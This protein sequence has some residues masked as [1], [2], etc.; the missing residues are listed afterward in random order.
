[1]WGNKEQ[2][3]F[4]L[5]CLGKTTKEEGTTCK[6]TGKRSLLKNFTGSSGAM[7]AQSAVDMTMRLWDADQVAVEWI[8]MDDEAS[9][10][11]ALQW[12]NDDYKLNFNTDVL[13]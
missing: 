7:E 5:W 12:S 2:A 4:H 3:M 10:R 6:A 8:C 11:A 13:P 1:L 9:T